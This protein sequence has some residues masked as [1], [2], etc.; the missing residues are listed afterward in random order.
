MLQITLARSYKRFTSE[1]SIATCDLNSTE[2]FFMF[3]CWGHPCPEG[4]LVRQ[5]IGPIYR[6][7]FTINSHR[8]VPSGPTEHWS[9]K[10]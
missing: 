10:P 3:L 4:P 1:N 8:V 2:Q 9:D 6:P 7:N 5:P